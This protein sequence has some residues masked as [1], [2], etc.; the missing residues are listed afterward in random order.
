MLRAALPMYDPPELRSETD[1][2][3]AKIAA[4]RPD[5]TE[6]S[7]ERPQTH[8][9]ILDLLADPNLFLSQTCWGPLSLNLL[10]DVEVIAQPDFSN[11]TGGIGPHYRSVIL[12]TGAGTDRSA[13][14]D[15][16]AD[17]PELASAEMTLAFNERASMSGY[18]C[19]ERDL[20]TRFN[21]EIETG[22]HRESLRAVA[23]GRAD[24][25]AVD[26]RTWA[27]LQRI[28]PAA[29][30]VHVIGWTAARTGLPY[31]CSPSLP[32]SLKNAVRAALIT[33]GAFAP[34]DAP[35]L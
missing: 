31:V 9:D 17:V 15:M 28:E 27:Q 11:F 20:P 4:L 25:A 14:T 24:I 12:A 8:A 7:F 26:C 6:I 16:A 32:Q 5:D 30:G 10:P 35:V 1:A 18:L 23:D 2:Q 29:T 19:L 3:W 13:P 21:A 22:G 34:S 33:T